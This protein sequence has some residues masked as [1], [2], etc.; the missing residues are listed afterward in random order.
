[1][2]PRLPLLLAAMMLAATVHAAQVP[3]PSRGDTRIRYV[4]YDPNNVVLIYT[5]IGASLLIQF[6]ADEQ[7][8]DMVGG[9]V[10]AWGAASTKAGNGIFLK[11]A[12]LAPETNIQVITTRRTYNFE[13]KLAPKGKPNYLNVRFRYPN[14]A[15]ASSAASEADQVR[16]L[17]DA[18]SPV[19]NRKYTVQ[20]SSGLAPV[21]AWD[22]GRTTFLRFR[23]RSEIPAVYATGGD[24]D[25]LEQVTKPV[26]NDDVAQVPGV[27]RK[28]VLRSGDQV[29]CVFNDGYEAN[30]PR[31][32]TSTASP[33]V[34]RTVKGTDK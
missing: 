6:E 12:G 23:A 4:T 26:T 30:V 16:A 9:D 8:V 14:E 1:M 13:I 3:E 25:S 19:G 21:E 18:G 15:H 29:A 22:D 2:S 31:P 24:D 28:L 27:H 34:R 11:P 20:G 7:L 17:L 5:K 10:D 32:A 33:T